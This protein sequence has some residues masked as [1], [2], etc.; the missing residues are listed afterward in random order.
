[1]Y[2]GLGHAPNAGP[3]PPSSFPVLFGYTVSGFPY[4][5]AIPNANRSG[6]NGNYNGNNGNGNNGNHNGNDYASY[7]GNNYGW[8]FVNHNHFNNNNGNTIVPYPV[9]IGGYN[10][11]PGY[12]GGSGDPPPPQGE[13]A[14]PPIVTTGQAPSVVI[15]Q[16]F[17]PDHAV[18]VVRDYPGP[19]DSQ[20]PDQSGLRTYEGLKT[21]PYTAPA[22]A[23]NARKPSDDQPTLYLIALKDHT[24]VQALGYWAENGS[25]H[26]VSAE[27]TLNQVSMDLIDR[28]LTQRLNDER[29]VEFK[30]PKL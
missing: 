7:K 29:N 22:A 24:I 23:A 8:R 18:P 21:P 16:T 27:H 26:Y 6:N 30:L 5:M 1:M 10:G 11:Y 20:N 4:P 14:P 25:L 12:Y 2:P 28:D 19:S 9:F 3:I 17:I 13:D 15:N